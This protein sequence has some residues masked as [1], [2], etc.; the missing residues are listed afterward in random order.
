M[1]LSAGPSDI[2]ELSSPNKDRGVLPF[3]SIVFAKR[4]LVDVDFGGSRLP[5][6]DASALDKS[7]KGPGL[8]SVESENALLTDASEVVGVLLLGGSN[9]P[10]KDLPISFLAV[11]GCGE[12]K[13]GAVE[14][15][16]LDMLPTDVKKLLNGF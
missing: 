7:L 16:E 1:T 14:V 3:W 8:G 6:V 12:K 13:L 15:D 10:N 11:V 5:S 2:P 9:A 4:L